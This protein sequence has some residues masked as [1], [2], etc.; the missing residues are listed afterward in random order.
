MCEKYSIF[1]YFLVCKGLSNDDVG[2]ARGTVFQEIR[3][4]GLFSKPMISLE[5]CWGGYYRRTTRD[6]GV[7]RSSVE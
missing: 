7:T 3:P 5:K 2:V 1:R 4:G 6:R